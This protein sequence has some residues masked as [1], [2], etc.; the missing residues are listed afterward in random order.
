MADGTASSV[1]EVTGL[2]ELQLRESTMGYILLWLIGIPIPI[3]II[4]A[5]LHH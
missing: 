5:L 4:L 3:L 2:N 1:E